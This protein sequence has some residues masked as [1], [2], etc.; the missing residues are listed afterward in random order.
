M[1]NSYLIFIIIWNCQNSHA[2]CDLGLSITKRLAVKEDDLQGFTASIPL[3]SM[4]YKSFEK[5]EGDDSVVSSCKEFICIG[6]L[7]HVLGWT[8][9]EEKLADSSLYCLLNYI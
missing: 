1:H 6:L 8:T 3:P 7:Y 9:E 4:V 2:I 5:Q